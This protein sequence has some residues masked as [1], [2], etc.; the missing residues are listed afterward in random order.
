MF[1]LPLCLLCALFVAVTAACP[2]GQKKPEDIAADPMSMIARAEQERIAPTAFK[3]WLAD[4]DPAVRARAVLAVARLEH[5]AALAPL[6][7][8]M[9]DADARVRATAAFGLGQLDLALDPAESEHQKVRGAAEKRLVEALSSEGDA[10]VRRAIVR[11]LGR[12]AD[13]A[14]LDA[15]TALSWSEDALRAEAF[16]ALGVSGARR[17]ASRSIDSQL[18]SSVAKA[19]SAASSGDDAV[20][21]GAAYAAFRQKLR[22]PL[23]ALKGAAN[24]ANVQARIFIMRAAPSQDDAGIDALLDV[25]LKD[26]DWRVRSEALRAASRPKSAAAVAK[27]IDEATVAVATAANDGASGGAAH[28]LR[29]A[30]MALAKSGIGPAEAKPAL[31]KA[32]VTLAPLGKHRSAACTCAVALD[33]V[34]PS[35][36]AIER[37]SVND[38]DAYLDILRVKVAAGARVPTKERVTSLAKFLDSDDVKVRM[39]AA[40]A[41][42]DDGSPEA[43]QAAAKALVDEE[44][45]GVV[46]TL[47]E[48]FSPE[49]DGA[50]LL[51]DS[52]LFQ[53]VERFRAASTGPGGPFEK[54]EPLVTVAKLARSRDTPTARAIVEELS[55]HGEPRVRDAAKGIASGDR[56]PGPRASVVAATSSSD[57]P[58]S[59]TL[60]TARGNV[61]IEFDKRHAPATVGNFVALA[62]AKAYDG[63]PFHRVI[64][65]FVAQGGDRRGDGSGGPGYTIACENSDEEYTRGAVGMATAGKDTGGSQFFLTHSHQPH[66][67]GRYTIFARVVDGFD[68]MDALQPDDILLGI[69]VA[70]PAATGGE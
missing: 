23:E 31:Q 63:T 52:V 53:L 70:A 48:L 57:L 11:A 18:V 33:V 3:S 32:V 46:T 29:E 66:L 19:L 30:C 51:A 15:L 43:A 20:K 62:R 56:E 16:T 68:V 65:D 10:N 21:A 47:I 39:Q 36:K 27:V 28:V 60:R 13:T 58:S 12:I 5:V 34:D 2:G 8:A 26:V 22:L 37:C 25:G 24:A 6:L 64:A 42:V 1:R 45:Y 69:D 41:L 54:V 67:D 4:E 50:D 7:A 17:K 40:A 35:N 9:D 38:D 44:D 49:S 59:A 61:R 14:G 55:G